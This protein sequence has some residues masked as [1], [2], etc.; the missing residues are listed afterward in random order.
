M[1]FRE[2]DLQDSVFHCG[3]AKTIARGAMKRGGR[4]GFRSVFLGL[5]DSKVFAC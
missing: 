1:F 3:F 4:V 2:N 5:L